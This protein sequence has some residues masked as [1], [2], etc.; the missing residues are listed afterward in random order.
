MRIRD[1]RFQRVRGRRDAGAWRIGT[2]HGPPSPRPSPPEEEREKLRRRATKR[3][4]QR[5][6]GRGEGGFRWLLV[7][8]TKYA[9][10]WERTECDIINDRHLSEDEGAAAKIR[11]GCPTVAHAWEGWEEQDGWDASQ[12]SWRRDAD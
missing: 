1:L 7:V 5:Q 6:W 11:A 12:Q 4:I 2:S 8:L 10:P 9:R 3:L